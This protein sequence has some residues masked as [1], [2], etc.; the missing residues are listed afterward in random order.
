MKNAEWLELISEK[1]EEIIAAGEQAFKDAV[2]NQHLQYEVILRADGTVDTWY[3]A[4]GG[5]SMLGS[6]Y[7]NEAITLAVMKIVDLDIVIQTSEYKEE[8]ERM[9][10]DLEEEIG[11]DFEDM[12]DW[13]ITQWIFE[14]YP[15]VDR[16]LEKEWLEWY[17]EEYAYQT[18][19][20]KL[21]R[22][23]EN[24]EMSNETL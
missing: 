24:L 16:K 7:N 4:Q 21:D 22:C 11:E 13:E 1:R 2:D 10:I 9:G 8:L 6:C 5:N 19:D 14:N 15:E 12:A 20:Y 3:Q 17:K 23:I 18:I